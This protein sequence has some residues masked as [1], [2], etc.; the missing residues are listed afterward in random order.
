M[1]P[2]ITDWE[3]YADRFYPQYLNLQLDFAEWTKKSDLSKEGLDFYR[4]RFLDF[5]KYN[6]NIIHARLGE[7]GRNEECPCGSGKKFK[8]CCGKGYI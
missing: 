5:F 8:A 2:Y 1:L 7:V 6:I 4:Q 3:L